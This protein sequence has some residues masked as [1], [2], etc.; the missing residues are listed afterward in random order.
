MGEDSARP[1]SLGPRDV[2]F[3]VGAVGAT[4]ASAYLYVAVIKHRS[5]EELSG[6]YQQTSA[7]P[8]TRTD[9][10]AAG[11]FVLY[12]DGTCQITAR[13]TV[14]ACEWVTGTDLQ[15]FLRLAQVVVIQPSSDRSQ[16]RAFDVSKHGLEPYQLWFGEQPADLRYGSRRS[17]PV[18]YSKVDD[19]S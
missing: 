19:G 17:G 3:F 15:A 12:P 11:G 13:S 14:A 4:I 18:I 6:S 7:P 5:V 1:S 8:G 2:A 9:G 10:A 16:W